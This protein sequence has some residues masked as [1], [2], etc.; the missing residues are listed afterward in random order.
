MTSTSEWIDI[1]VALHNH[2]PR[3]PGDPGI[4]IQQEA[5]MLDGATVNLTRLEM[6]VHTGT[7]M[8]APHHFVK[9]GATID[10]VPLT[11]VIGPARVIQIE[12]P[13][14]IQMAE[15]EAQNI[16]AGE[17][18]LFKTQNSTRDWVKEPFRKKFVHLS[19]ETAQY[20]AQRQIR[21]VGVDYLSVSG[22]QSNET[23]VHLALLHA[24]IWIIEGLNL[25]GVEAGRYE[26]VC[27]P[28][29]IAQAD[30]APARVVLRPFVD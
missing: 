5:D 18:I 11:T 26:L 3:W 24:G 28:L 15:V 20:L 16:R 13:A 9:D 10:Q 25:A 27:L 14:A 1:S 6:G 19:T 12:D 30:G 4:R 17:R 29:K 2:M 8:D 21:L 7:H 22:Y 23:E